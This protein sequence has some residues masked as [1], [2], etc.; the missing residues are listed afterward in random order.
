MSH[1]PYYR[2]CSSEGEFLNMASII[3]ENVNENRWV[4]GYD[5]VKEK[6]IKRNP[7]AAS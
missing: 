7:V 6:E 4:A 2:V 1:F 5:Y 3:P